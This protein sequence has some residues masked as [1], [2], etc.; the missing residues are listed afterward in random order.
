MSSSCDTLQFTFPHYGDS[1][2]CKINLLREEHHFCDITLILGNPDGS[3]AQ[4]LRFHGHKVVLAASS[5]FLR[6]QFRLHEGQAELNV[7][8]V[9]SVRIAKSLL[10]SCYTGLLEVPLKELVNYLTASS[11]LQMSQVVEKCVQAISQYLSPTPAFFKLEIHCT[12]EES[13]QLNSSWKSSNFENQSEKVV[14]QPSAKIWEANN[15]AGRTVKSQPDLKTSQEECEA[16]SQELKVIRKDAMVVKVK[17]ELSETFRIDSFKSE[18]CE[19]FKP[20]P[21]PS[22]HVHHTSTSL[23]C[24]LHPPAEVQ[25][26]VSSIAPKIR[27]PEDHE[28]VTETPPEQH[29]Q[30]ADDPTEDGNLCTL[31]HQFQQGRELMDSKQSGHSG[32]GMSK[33]HMIAEDAVRHPKNELVQRPYLCRKCDRLFQHLENYEGHLKEHRQYFCLVCGEAF[34]HKTKLIHHINI[35]NSTKPFRCPLC[36]QMFTQKA[37]LQDHLHLHTGQEPHKW[38]QHLALKSSLAGHVSEW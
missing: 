26:F 24:K 9:S 17:K 5:D 31:V 27:N 15:Q 8:V 21:N 20:F 10:L 35:H 18:E 30:A 4:P 19:D 14:V 12:G 28:V 34:F 2:L 32:A 23:N 36:H 13:Q 3:T 29:E 11:A 6:D 25:H 22:H 1:I 7:G 37:L 16:V 33:N 38:D